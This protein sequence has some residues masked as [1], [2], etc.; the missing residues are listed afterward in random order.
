[1]N[2]E[3]KKS[4]EMKRKWR[5]HMR[6]CYVAFKMKQEKI[7]RK[8]IVHTKDEMKRTEGEEEEEM[9]EE[10]GSDVLLQLVS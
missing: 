2:Y 10:L 3:Y 1:M 4:V 7:E 6:R 8:D 9:E 5:Q